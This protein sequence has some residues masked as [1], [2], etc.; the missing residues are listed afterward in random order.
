MSEGDDQKPPVTPEGL[1][2]EDMAEDVSD[3]Q[4]PKILSRRRYGRRVGDAGGLGNIWMISFTDVMALMLTFFVLLFAMS[5]PDHEKWE[6]LA[7]ALQENFNKFYGKPLSRGTADAINIEKIN[8][9]QALDLN[10]LQALLQSLVDKEASLE[11]VLLI[12]QRRSLIISLPQNVLFETGSTDVKEEARRALFTIAGSLAR[13]Q[14][15]VE[16]I[17]HA[18][19]RPVTGG[20]YASNWE[21]SLARAAQVAAVLEN[22]GYENDVMIRGQAS[23]R[24]QDLPDTMSEEARQ[25]L[26]RRVD[27]VIMEDDG[28][29]KKLFDIGM[30]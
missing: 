18:D 20:E 14:N 30:P 7:D 5:N 15:R 10:Y 19:P 24:Y 13:I 16:I 8:Y 27:I 2:A 21:L 11:D 9:N 28:E 1:S 23:G 4:P 26:S 25:E 17:G 6:N 12:T 22:V 29:R 3:A